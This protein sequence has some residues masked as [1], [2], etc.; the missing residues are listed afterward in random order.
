M[1][2]P[3]GRT[4]KRVVLETVGWLLVV[5]GVAALILPGPGLLAIMA[6]LIVLSQQYE[7]A[8]RRLDPVKRR[9]LREAA[10]GVSG[11]LPMAVTLFGIVALVACGVLW[12]MDPPAPSWW[13]LPDSWWLPGG[14]WTAVTQFG[15]A[16]I[17]LGLMIYSFR[18]FH[19]KPEALAALDEEDRASAQRAEQRAGRRAA[20]R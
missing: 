10:R 17:A 9:A 1:N 12:T 15:S 2:V 18:R 16:A 20:S 3:V 6:G 8:E 4:V 13:S 11:P 19:G 7:W 14:I 5:V